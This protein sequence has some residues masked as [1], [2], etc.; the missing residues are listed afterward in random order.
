MKR[1]S[2]SIRNDI[3][4]NKVTKKCD[5]F[6]VEYKNIEQVEKCYLLTEIT[7]HAVYLYQLDRGYYHL[8]L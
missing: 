4:S 7:A 6:L 8:K 3:V 1:K 5:W 2:I